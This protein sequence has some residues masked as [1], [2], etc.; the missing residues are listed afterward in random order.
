MLPTT[1]DS[2]GALPMM[3]CDELDLSFRLHCQPISIEDRH[4]LR[5]LNI[6]FPANFGILIGWSAIEVCEGDREPSSSTSFTISKTTPLLRVLCS[7]EATLLHCQ[8]CFEV[9]HTLHELVITLPKLQFHNKLL[10]SERLQMS[11][12]YHGTDWP[13][14]LYICTN[15]SC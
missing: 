10:F 15:L 4:A 11:S 3:L 7:R 1:G 14:S 5:K 12:Q 13:L 6:N 9:L 2:S 8:S